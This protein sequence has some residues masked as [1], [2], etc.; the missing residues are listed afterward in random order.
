M[1]GCSQENSDRVADVGAGG[2]W[3]SWDWLDNN[4]K[5]SADRIVPEW[6]SLDVGQQLKGP[7]NWRAVVV[8]E[9]DRTLVLRS[10]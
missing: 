2:S 4:G 7:A 8:A 9:P 1:C 6:Q 5:P 3:Y 10:S